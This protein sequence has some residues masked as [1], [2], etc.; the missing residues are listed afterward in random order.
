MRNENGGLNVLPPRSRS[1]IQRAGRDQ[2]HA[3]KRPKQPHMSSGERKI[4]EKELGIENSKLKERENLLEGEIKSMQ[5]KLKYIDN[6]IK[7]RAM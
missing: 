7:T 3:K 5:T 1:P 6:L 2:V 4:R